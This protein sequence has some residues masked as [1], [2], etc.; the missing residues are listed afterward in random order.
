MTELTSCAASPPGREEGTHHPL[1]GGH[2]SWPRCL[3]S[4]L[5]GCALG[6]T[7]MGRGA[8]AS[9]TFSRASVG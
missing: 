9:S 7:P 8:G 5:S 4:C 1:A 3:C 2:H 6:L